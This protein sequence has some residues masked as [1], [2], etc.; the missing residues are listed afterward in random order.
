MKRKRINLRKGGR[1]LAVTARAAGAALLVLGA[2]G[3]RQRAASAQ[4]PVGSAEGLQV[5]LLSAISLDFARTNPLPASG[6][7]QSANV[8]SVGVAGLG[9]LTTGVITASTEGTPLNN[10]TNVTSLATV[11]GLNLFPPI[12]PGN[13]LLTASTVSST[14]TA[15]QFS[16][17]VGNTT[18]TNLMF[19]G[20]SVTV[21][22]T[23]N[24]TVEIAG[25]ARL[26]INEQTRSGNTLTTNALHLTVLDGLNAGD[27][28][29]SQSVAGFSGAA[30]PEP[31]AGA[32]MLA[33]GPVL[34]ALVVRARRKR[35]AAQRG[36]DA[37]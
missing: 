31:G 23:V 20:S 21:D 29:V 27:V 25:V 37:A 2:V 3:T 10:V 30:A 17:A 34:P 18:I 15:S 22:G 12:I 9:Y 7:V 33:F 16:S 26:V 35:S 5:R 6:A 32:L 4:T 28:I 14:T 13:S 36:N 8:A 1:A 24:Q 11:N 19:N